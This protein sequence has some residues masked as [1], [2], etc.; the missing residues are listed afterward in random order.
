MG[1]HVHAGHGPGQRLCVRAR[2]PL[3]C[4]PTGGLR[5][6]LPHAFRHTLW[7]TAQSMFEVSCFILILMKAGC[8]GFS[9]LEESFQTDFAL[10]LRRWCT[11]SSW[12]WS[13]RATWLR[14]AL[15]SL[16]RRCTSACALCSQRSSKRAPQRLQPQ[17]CSLTTSFAEA[18]EGACD[19][20]AD[21]DM[22]THMLLHEVPCHTAPPAA[23]LRGSCEVAQCTMQ[24]CQ[25]RGQQRCSV[26]TRAPR[27]I[28]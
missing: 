11:Q 19:R 25:Q 28:L 24:A 10:C 6:A 1:P 26:R 14:R 4:S 13:T 7:G 15:M 22:A 2:R 12:T 23:S 17:V 20:T 9:M 5:H 8:G 3:L 16:C 27:R 21:S 18:P